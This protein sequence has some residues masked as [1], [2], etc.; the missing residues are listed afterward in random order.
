MYDLYTHFVRVSISFL[1]SSLYLWV[2][3]LILYI[4]L[5]QLDEV[6]LDS[7]YVILMIKN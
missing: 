3:N 5:C 7:Y 1:I 2:H 4:I 6:K